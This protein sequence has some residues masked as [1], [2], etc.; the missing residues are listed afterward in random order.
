MIIYCSEVKARIINGLNP[1]QQ[2]ETDMEKLNH[3]VIDFSE[4]VY[5][6]TYNKEA[7]KKLEETKTALILFVI[8][9]ILLL[10][11]FNQIWLKYFS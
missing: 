11:L 2:L 8:V 7:I 6:E 1:E 3:R 9:F 4:V 10:Q 5:T